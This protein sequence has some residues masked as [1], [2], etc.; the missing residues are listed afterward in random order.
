M[1]GRWKWAYKH[2]TSEG[3]IIWGGMVKFSESVAVVAYMRTCMTYKIQH[4][5]AGV[6]V[7]AG[8]PTMGPN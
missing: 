4:V 7:W 1:E 6:V 2:G 5:H 8:M 3:K